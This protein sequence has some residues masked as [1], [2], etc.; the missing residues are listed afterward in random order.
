ML[1]SV[2]GGSTQS[3]SL[4]LPGETAGQRLDQALAVL[5]GPEFSRAQ[6]Q[7]LIEEG[8]VSVSGQAAR[9]SARVK[10]GEAVAVELPPPTPLELVPEPLS[11]D[12]I[13]ED[14]QFLVVNKPVGL[15][16]HPAP[17]HS[18][19]TLVHGLLHHCSDLSGIGGKLRP[20]IVHRLDKDTSGALVVAKNDQAHRSLAAAF[21]SG[22]VEKL[23]LALVWGRPPQSG[24]ST[25]GIGRHPADRKRMSS[26]GRHL[27]AADTR[28]EVR[29]VFEPGVSLLQVR[30]LT[31]RTHQIRVH[32]AEAG[33]PVLGDPVYGGRLGR[34]SLP[35]P[36]GQLLKAAGRQM[37]HAARLALTHPVTQERMEFEAPLPPDFAA[38]LEALESVASAGEKQA[39]SGLPEPALGAFWAKERGG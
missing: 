7:R 21:A 17:G 34:R 8:R 36:A 10:G 24:Q 1:P 22:R 13:Y 31:G 26:Q 12:I 6:V 28:W 4:T 16:V 37:L 33:F 27:K 5:L 23:Y 3:L 15:V 18:T 2:P 38:V 11:L 25:S 14:D 39:G 29:R 19:G 32:L 9:G 20:G 30:I 35:G